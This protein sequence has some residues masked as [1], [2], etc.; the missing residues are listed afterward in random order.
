MGIIKSDRKAQKRNRLIRLVFLIIILVFTTVIGLLHQYSK[1]VK[2][3]G[4]DAFC[5]F[6]GIESAFT[7][8]TAGEMIKR[9]TMSSFIL[10]IATIIIALIFR[11]SFCGN[12]C[13]FGAL[14]ELFG[15]LGSAIFRKR[16]ELPGKFDR[17]ARYLKYAAL[18]FIVIFSWKTGELIIRPYDPWAAYHHVL[19]SE[20]F[21]EFKIGFI[22]L[23]VTLL[24]SIVLD[25]FF[26]KYLC[27]MGAFLGMIYRGGWFRIRRSDETCTHCMACDKACPVNIKVESKEEVKSSECINCNLCVN[28]CPV[29][30]T[31]FI[32]GPKKQ[33]VSPALLL[34]ITIVIFVAVPGI[35]TL[36][37]TVEWTIKPLSE[38]IEETGSFDPEEIRGS[39]TY[40]EISE[41]TGIPEKD[42]KKRFNI[43]GEEF[44]KPIK[45]SAHKPDSGFETEDVREFVRERINQ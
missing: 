42:F 37:G 45:E 40:R 5:P 4:V 24:G 32:S 25:R 10:L 41:I 33:R 23:I 3:A 31:L 6:G 17:V 20:L 13:A 11:R 28:A 9:V 12:I 8:I 18:L 14:Q 21:L 27:P 19:S 34:W 1:G 7:L 26:C 16:P 29:K 44:D 39:N 35:S 15:R 22:V 2:P 36:T 38:T 30:D 43:S